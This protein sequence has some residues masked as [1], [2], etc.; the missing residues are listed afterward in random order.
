[1]KQ[2]IKAFTLNAVFSFRITVAFMEIYYSHTCFSVILTNT[3]LC[4]VEYVFNSIILIS[5]DYGFPKLCE[6]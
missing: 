1:M 4:T 5:S 6:L 3:Y 2:L